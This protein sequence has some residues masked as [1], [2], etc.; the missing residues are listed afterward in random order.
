MLNTY[1]SVSIWALIMEHGTIF[2]IL[3]TTFVLRTTDLKIH[4][5]LGTERLSGGKIP[6]N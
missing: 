5:N 3:S 4:F 1:A 2:E 6:H